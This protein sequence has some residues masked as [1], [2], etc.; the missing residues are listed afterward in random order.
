[1]I[2]IMVYV[3]IG[4][5]LGI[6]AVIFFEEWEYSNRLIE[7]NNKQ[8]SIKIQQKQI[9]EEVDSLLKDVSIEKQ[10]AIERCQS[11]VMSKSIFSL[12]DIEEQTL[13]LQSH[14]KNSIGNAS[15]YKSN[16][17]EKRLLKLSPLKTWR[18]LKIINEGLQNAA[19]HSEANFIFSIASVENEKLNIITHDNGIGYDRKV[20][21]DGNGINTI[22]KTV[23]Q[24]DGDLK[25]TSTTGNGTV[26]NVEIPTS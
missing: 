11:F 2:D 18:I 23:Q 26:V 13:Q 25:L 6:V 5:L 3:L 8:S 21:K 9:L 24:L 16:F 10:V 12:K 19:M 20:I 1:M 4:L 7:N 15:T 17:P 22:L 14:Y